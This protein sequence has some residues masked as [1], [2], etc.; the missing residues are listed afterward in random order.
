MYGP[1]RNKGR[2]PVPILVRLMAKVDKQGP[3]PAGRPELGPCWVYTGNKYDG[4]GRIQG[5]LEG[6][7]S[8]HRVAYQ[9]MVGPIPPGLE[10]DHLCRNR[11]C[12]NPEHLEAVTHR[13][14]MLR[15][16]CFTGTNGRKSHCKHGHEFTPENTL[17]SRG[18]RQCRQCARDRWPGRREAYNA[19]RRARYQKR[20]SVSNEPAS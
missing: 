19:A 3:T 14:N 10:L 5:R 16:E 4:Y 11:A 6:A 9:E 2:K 7:L 8:A 13:E 18:N 17:W 1:R 20:K 12:V 15:S